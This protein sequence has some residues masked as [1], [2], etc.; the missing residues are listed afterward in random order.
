MSITIYH[1]PRCS[2]SRDTLRILADSGAELEIIEYLKEPPSA[3]TIIGLAG[4]LGM[5]V[6]QLLRRAEPEFKQASDLP[7]LDD[8]DALAIWL[9]IH[10]KVLQRPIVL[11]PDGRAVIGR[12]PENVF[13]LIRE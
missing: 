3:A 9:E 13:Q 5:T 12:P 11:S 10:P 2:K 4:R 1:N 8:D 6:A 7:G